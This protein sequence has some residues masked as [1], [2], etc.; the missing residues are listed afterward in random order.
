MAR[1]KEVRLP[2]D[3]ICASPAMSSLSGAEFGVLVWLIAE[4]LR[5][6]PEGRFIEDGKVFSL[7]MLAE[8]SPYR[9][10]GALGCLH[11]LQSAGFL[12]RESDGVF[13]L[14]EKWRQDEAGEGCDE[15]VLSK[16]HVASPRIVPHHHAGKIQKGRQPN[17]HFFLIGIC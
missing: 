12:S 15:P 13:R 17:N 10:G 8:R 9:G 11:G 1:R 6:F 3:W 7:R 16:V 4:K 14:V 2:A 5:W